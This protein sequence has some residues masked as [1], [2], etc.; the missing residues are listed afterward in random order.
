[1][2]LKSLIKLINTSENDRLWVEGFVKEY[3]FDTLVE[4]I[5][6]ATISN[7]TKQ[8]ILHIDQIIHNGSQAIQSLAAIADIPVKSL[9]ASL[10]NNNIYELLE[11]PERLDVDSRQL[12]KMRCVHQVYTSNKYENICVQEAESHLDMERE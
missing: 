10:K 7:R 4:H 11:H 2:N 9:R 1:M 6:A 12:Y 5:A 8:T 3:S